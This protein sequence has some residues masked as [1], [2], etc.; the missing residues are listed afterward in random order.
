MKVAI[1]KSVPL[2]G[3]STGDYALEIRVH[4][5]FSGHATQEVEGTERMKLVRR[6]C[7]CDGLFL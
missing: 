5:G 2:N 6:D 1:T 4:H 7:V 3:L